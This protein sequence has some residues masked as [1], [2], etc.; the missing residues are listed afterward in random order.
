MHTRDSHLRRH[1]LVLSL[2]TFLVCGNSS[3]A[4]PAPAKAKIQEAITKAQK[5][6]SGQPLTG[7]HGAIA[8]LAYVKSGGDKKAIAVQGVVK[9]VLN[10]CKVKVYRP[11]AH[12][13]YEAGVDIM[14]LEA[15]DPELYRPEMEAITAYLLYQQQPNGA[16][17]YPH[18]IESDCGDTSITQYAILGL[19]AAARVGI[20]VPVETWERAAQ[21]HITKQLSDGGFAYHP[22]DKRGGQNPEHMVST[23][24][25][26]AAGSSN[27]LIIRRVLFEDADMDSEVRPSDS[28]KR[29]GVLERF[30]DDKA[31]PQKKLISGV[32]TMK[33]SAIDKALKDSVRWTANHFAEKSPNHEKFFTYHFYCVERIAALMDVERLGSHDWYE[34]GAAELLIR[35]GADGSWNDSCTPLASTAL[36]LMFLSKA[37]TTVVIPKKKLLLLGGGLQIGGRGL[38]D[39]LDAVQVKDGIAKA[40]KIAGPV[41]TLLIELERAADAKVEDVQ[42]A[43]VESVQLDRPEDLIGQVKRLRK[44]ATDQRVE[45]RRTAVWALGRSNDVSAATLLIQALSDP[46]PSVI[47]EA[48]LALTILSRR[49]EG[50]GKAIDPFDDIET[51]IKENASEEQ[52]KAFLEEWRTES[53]KRWNDWYLKQRSYDDRDDRMTLK[54]TNK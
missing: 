17:F 53:K 48:S 54:R 51:G 21:W 25:M 28:K 22:F 38:P 24:T 20:E 46:D 39:N 44:L 1:L 9:E 12:H 50:C 49:P 3:F 41:D 13:N 8:A 47:R 26:S 18:E 45:V 5:F 19:W 14:L 27:L 15:I 32:P 11:V 2:M 34:E 35:Q 29:F 33:P 4:A 23:A 31:G 10:K 7:G 6:L 52:R 16:W 40:R 37:T 42:A 43:V 30:I 36:G